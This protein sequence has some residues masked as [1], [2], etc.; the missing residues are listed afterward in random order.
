MLTTD[1]SLP[2][3]LGV[4]WS[5]LLEADSE[6]PSFISHAACARSVYPHHQP[7]GL[8][9]LD[10][11]NDRAVLIQRGEASVQVSWFWHGAAPSGCPATMVPS[12]RRLPHS[13]STYP[14]CSK[15]PSRLSAGLCATPC[16]PPQHARIKRSRGSPR[17]RLE[18]CLVIES[19]GSSASITRDTAQVVLQ[20]ESASDSLHR[21]QR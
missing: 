11:C 17:S 1:G 2:Q 4:V 14:T 12:P 3:Q 19:P 15:I 16:W 9:H 13:I 20:F 10:H 18:V 8:A 7:A 6:G 21:S 5:R